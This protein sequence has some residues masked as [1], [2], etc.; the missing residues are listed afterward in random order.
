MK[1]GQEDKMTRGREDKSTREQK[2]KRT[3]YLSRE[4]RCVIISVKN[5]DDNCGRCGRDGHTIV[6]SYH[7]KDVAIT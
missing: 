1:G 7:S 4:G 5:C 3:T 2:D 6:R